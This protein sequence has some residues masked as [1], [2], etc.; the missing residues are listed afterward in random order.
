MPATPKAPPTAIIA[1][2]L[3]GTSQRRTAAEIGGKETDRHH[4]EDMIETAERMPEA[5]GEAHGG[6][7]PGMG[8]GCCRCDQE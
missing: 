8:F 6:S 4:G 3:N 7:D 2:K 5:M 1:T